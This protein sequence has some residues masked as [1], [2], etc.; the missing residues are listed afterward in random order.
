MTVAPSSQPPQPWATGEDPERLLAAVRD[1]PGVADAQLYRAGPEPAVLQLDLVASADESVV[2]VAVARLLDERFGVAVDSASVALVERAAGLSAPGDLQIVA[3][4]VHS[5][6]RRATA[7]VRLRHGEREEDGSA[8]GPATAAGVLTAV[9]GAVADAVESLSD[10]ALEVAVHDVSVTT[11]GTVR[12]RLAVGAG[13]QVRGMDA[14]ESIR[15]DPRQAA[16]RA[17]AG[18]LAG[19]L[20]GVPAGS[21]EVAPLG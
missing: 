18:L 17:A 5:E 20:A 21:P 2:A 8:A 13:G 14:E 7:S 1:V 9:V 12:V 19:P 10:G 4:T 3:V 15:S 11:G 6:G 16:A